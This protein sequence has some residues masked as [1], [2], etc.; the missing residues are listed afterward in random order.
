MQ[1]S[2]GTASSSAE[3]RAG[4]K[5]K[6]PRDSRTRSPSPKR[7]CDSSAKVGTGEPDGAESSGVCSEEHLGRETAQEDYEF[8][9]TPKWPIPDEKQRARIYDE[10][11]LRLHRPDS[12]FREVWNILTTRVW[13][14]A[15]DNFPPSYMWKDLSKENQAEIEVWASHAQE[16]ME[17][18]ERLR[19]QCFFEAWIFR[20]LYDHLFSPE[21]QDK[22]SCEMWKIYGQQQYALRGYL[23]G[24]DSEEGMN[25]NF[26]VRFHNWRSMTAEMTLHATG[27]RWHTEPSRL[28]DILL[29]RLGP[30]MSDP[31]RPFPKN[32]DKNLYG[33]VHFAIE[34]DLLMIYSSLWLKLEMKV[35]N[36]SVIKDFAY[37]YKDMATHGCFYS[38]SKAAKSISQT[39]D[40]ISQPSFAIFGGTFTSME[41]EDHWKAVP[42]FGHEFNLEFQSPSLVQ[43]AINGGE[44]QGFAPATTTLQDTDAKTVED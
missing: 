44:D 2:E 10:W 25:S 5:R 42:S 37:D 35:P 23:D 30:L 34:L 17:S 16:W 6:A 19:A 12:I 31:R 3:E 7:P 20:L 13:L 8:D 39:V 27:R 43:L 38:P 40:F 36:M 41:S 9:T 18:S 32:L 33:I 1:H 11:H 14:L 24:P 28:K 4:M 29:D 21:C 22:W 26:N 15:H